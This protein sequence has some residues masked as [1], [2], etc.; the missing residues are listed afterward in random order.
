MLLFLRGSILYESG[1]KREGL[2][3]MQ[4][5]V[6]TNE[7][8][9]SLLDERIHLSLA[10]IEYGTAKTARE[11]LRILK[12][13]SEQAKL[14]FDAIKALI[15]ASLELRDYKGISDALFNLNSASDA[16]A[17]AKLVK[18]YL[19][20]RELIYRCAGNLPRMLRLA[21]GS[22]DLTKDQKSE[23]QRQIREI[24]KLLKQGRDFQKTKT[25]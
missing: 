10:L 23:F 19:E 12:L 18:P 21:L 7:G 1:R 14:P 3:L 5:V 13:A 24:E 20:D 16:A 2:N 8:N 11:G 17:I 9:P 25:L 22:D 15:K 4:F 6:E